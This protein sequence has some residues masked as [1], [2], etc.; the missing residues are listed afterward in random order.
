MKAI[1]VLSAGLMGLILLAATT[2][3][4]ANPV[5]SNENGHYYEFVPAYGISYDAAK[6][7][8][9]ASSYLGVQGHLATVTT[10][11]ED[12]FLHNNFSQQIL[13]VWILINDGAPQAW[14]GGF[15]PGPHPNPSSPDPASG[16]QW[17][18]GET[19][20]YTGWGN[21]EPNGGNSSLSNI[22]TIDL[23]PALGGWNDTFAD[24]P[25]V[26]GYIVEYDVTNAPANN[27]AVNIDFQTGANAYAGVGVLGSGSDTIWNPVGPNGVGGT[28][29]LYADGSGPSG[30]SIN[31]RRFADCADHSRR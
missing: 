1:Y 8:A 25:G 23:R 13:G 5:Q 16:W 14:L 6:A 21:G 12:T 7:A 19:W 9:A 29:L 22:A 11:T 24:T 20:N 10:P 17:I 30:V 27:P 26:E 18:T 28:N 15:S 4:R 2:T 3:A 31:D